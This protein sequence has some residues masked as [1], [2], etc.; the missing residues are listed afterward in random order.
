[1]NEMTKCCWGYWGDLTKPGDFN[2]I[3]K[4]GETQSR[5]DDCSCP[6]HRDLMQ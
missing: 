2:G 3:T 1:M 5:N 4:A 6:G